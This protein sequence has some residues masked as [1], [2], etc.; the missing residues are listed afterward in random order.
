[1]NTIADARWWTKQL[2]GRLSRAGYLRAGRA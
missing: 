2:E 1:M